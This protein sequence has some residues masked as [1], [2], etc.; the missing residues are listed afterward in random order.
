MYN[1]G[2]YSV[3]NTLLLVISNVLC[4]NVHVK[5]RRQQHTPLLST[6]DLIL[7]VRRYTHVRILEFIG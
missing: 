4:R 5:L 2:I 6:F 1:N 7:H 3:S